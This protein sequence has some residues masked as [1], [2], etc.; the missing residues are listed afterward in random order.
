MSARS[1]SVPAGV[2]GLLSLQQMAAILGVHPGQLDRLVA[3]GCPAIDVAVPREG[4]RPKRSLR[5]DRDRVLAWL[6]N[7]ADKA[8][9][10]N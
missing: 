3:I 7:R 6:S 8:H 1:K 5:F 4:R 2:T 9:G 10:G